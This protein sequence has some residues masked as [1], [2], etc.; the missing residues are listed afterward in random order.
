MPSQS[1]L[2]Y[3]K[4]REAILSARVLPGDHLAEIEWS[5]RLQFGRFAIR[6]GLKRLHGEGLVTKSKGKHRVTVMTADEIREIVHLRAVLEIGALRFRKG[7]IPGKELRPIREAARDYSSLVKKGYYD[8]AREADLRFHRAIIATSQNPRLVRLYESSNLPLLQVT[9]G[10]SAVPLDDF[11][12]AAQEHLA[13]CK[14]LENGRTEEATKGLEE[15]LKRGE[16]EVI[17]FA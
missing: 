11:E 8:G 14:A 9:V 13:I 7:P 2:A 6:E 1:E 5:D 12:L 3:Q 10:Q 4:L 16:R 15:H 17:G